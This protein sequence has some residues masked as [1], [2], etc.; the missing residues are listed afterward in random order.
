MSSTSHL[1]MSNHGAFI[2]GCSVCKYVDKYFLKGN[3]SRSQFHNALDSFS[4]YHSQVNHLGTKFL[5]E[6]ERNKLAGKREVSLDYSR[7]LLLAQVRRLTKE[8]MYEESKLIAKVIQ[9]VFSEIQ[10][11]VQITAVNFESMQLILTWNWDPPTVS[12]E[13]RLVEFWRKACEK[14]DCDVTIRTKDGK[15]YAHSFMLKNTSEYFKT[16][17]SFPQEQPPVITLTE[18]S[19][20][21]ARAYL[22]FLYTTQIS[23]IKEYS[24]QD[25]CELFNLSEMHLNSDMSQLCLFHINTKSTKDERNE[26]LSQICNE[27]PF[28]E[29][30]IHL[31]LEWVECDNSLE[32]SFKIGLSKIDSNRLKGLQEIALKNNLTEVSEILKPM[33]Q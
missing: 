4:E 15:L 25:L 27:P 6:V 12:P 33:C 11:R 22:E 8:R 14:E 21:M 30:L 7:S 10:I 32:V 2:N 17:I 24:C 16:A 18:T 20:K 5:L 23:N 3:S 1:F 29:K 19:S 31:L 13:R 26:M 9:G 28:N